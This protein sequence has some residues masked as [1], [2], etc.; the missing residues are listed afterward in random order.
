MVRSHSALRVGLLATGLIILFV[1]CR[2]DSHLLAP[3]VVQEPAAPLAEVAMNTDPVIAGAGDIASCS[4]TGDEATAALLDAINPARV[5]TLGDNAYSSGTLTE[6]NNC[7][8]P[9]WGR[10]KTIT[11]PSAGDAD[12]KTTGA[13]GYFDYFGAAAGDRTKGYYS[14]D[15]GE[16]HII[17]LNSKLST[18]A[19]SAQVQWLKSDLAASAKLCTVAYWHLPLFSSSSTGVRSSIRPIWDVLYSAGVELVINGNHKF[20]ERFAPQTPTGERDEAY[21]IREFVVST[22]GAGTHSFGTILPNSEARSSGTHGVLKLVLGAGRY[23]WEFVPVAGKTFT[24]A[25][26]G[27]CHGRPLPAARPGGP[28]MAEDTVRFDGSKSSDP[29]GDLPLSYAWDFGDGAH[30][31][32][33]KPIHVYSTPGVYTV[34]LV[35][36]DAVGDVSEA[37][38][39]TVQIANL[40]PVVRAGPDKRTHPAEPVA[41]SVYFRDRADDA[42]WTYH[43]AWGDGTEESGTATSPDAPVE[44][45]H[46][47]AM[48]GAFPVLVSLT[49]KDGGVGSDALQVL[50]REPG[51]PEVILAAGDI[52]TCS[53]NR[54]ESTAK[55]LDVLEGTVFTLG[56][57]AYPDGARA[58]YENCYHPTW[59]RHRDRTYA[60]LGNH[61]YDLGHAEG[62]FEYFASGVGPRG[63][64]YYSLDLGDWHII[65]LNDNSAYVPFGAGS[66]QDRWLQEDLATRSKKC[67]L[68]IWHQPLFYSNT[69][70]TTV[71]TTRKILWDRL[72]PAGVDLVLNAHQHRYERFAPQDPNGVRN[73]VTG[74]RQ[75]IVGTGGDGT[76][77]ATYTAA[78][79]EVHDDAYGVLKLTLYQDG[80]TWEFVPAGSETFT[81]SGSG[82]CH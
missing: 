24:D 19:T 25:G 63:K 51:T 58:D 15:L 54:D 70:S 81:D 47:Y 65:V 37:A 4:K 61:E 27:A 56:D 26:S 3:V 69:S 21:G 80:Y 16:W 40:P 33:A 49:D 13:A 11:S 29:Q 14:Y 78:N 71:R 7:Y 68:A 72:Y 55:L 22:G 46:V 52:S 76:S 20:Y 36:T 42:P 82:V 2:D 62:S 30:G 45:S 59:G 31:T 53:N 9:T 10:H 12:Y 8:G 67:T 44:L 32:G 28:Y 38:T 73:D 60:Q 48:T 66:E 34:T 5:F 43:V 74:I 79:S 23:A 39:T 35:V 57:N 77:N 50:V 17:V 75:F 41:V 6:Y 18:S 1:T 64:G